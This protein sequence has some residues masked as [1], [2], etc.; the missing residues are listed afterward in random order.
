MEI[1]FLD[2]SLTI[3]NN[4]FLCR[5]SLFSLVHEWNWF[6]VTNDREALS[7]INSSLFSV[8]QFPNLPT[9]VIIEASFPGII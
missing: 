5:K 3:L 1:T 4:K 2:Y 6:F 8:S 9:F 7:K